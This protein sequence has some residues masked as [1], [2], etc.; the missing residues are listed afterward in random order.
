MGWYQRRVHGGALFKTCKWRH[1][2]SPETMFCWAVYT[3][4][5]GSTKKSY[6]K[7][8]LTQQHAKNVSIFSCNAYAVYS[9]A[10]VDLGGGLSS[11]KVTDKEGDLHFAKRKTT[12]AWV[13]TGMFKQIWAALRDA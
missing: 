2:A 13:N 4:N 7:E 11:I 1:L 3:Q 9:D 12:G 10:Q 5:T 8:L 6:E